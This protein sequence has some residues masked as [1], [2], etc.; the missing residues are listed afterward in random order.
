M[1]YFEEKADQVSPDTMIA[2]GIRINSRYGKAWQ[3]SE[4]LK[5]TQALAERDLHACVESVFYDS[6]CD[7]CSFELSGNGI[8]P[9]QEIA[10][11]ACANLH[12]SQFDWDGTIHHGE[13]MGAV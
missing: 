6:K 13:P 10:I 4:M 9:A 2:F 5:F 11:L 7:T 3:M 8:T 12:I 1:D